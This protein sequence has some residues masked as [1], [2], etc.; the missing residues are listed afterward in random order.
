MQPL[1]ELKTR[2]KIYPANCSLSM[3]GI[4]WCVKQ[5]SLKP[6]FHWRSLAQLRPRYC[7]F[8]ERCLHYGEKLELVKNDKKQIF[9]TC[10]GQWKQSYVWSKAR[11]D[12]YTL[13]MFLM[14]HLHWRHLLAI[15]PAL[16]TSVFICL[17]HL[18]WHSTDRIISI[19]CHAACRKLLWARAFLA[20]KIY[21]FV[22][23]NARA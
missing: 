3:R 5:H 13:A 6:Y 21:F 10:L 9:L 23:Q 7:A 11:K 19:F 20:S 14:D 1:L 2:P 8:L 18:G 17:G 22:L 16:A 12:S 4:K 15:T